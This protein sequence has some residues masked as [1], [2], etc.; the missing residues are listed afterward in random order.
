MTATIERVL[1]YLLVE[2]NDDHADLVERCF[3]YGNVPGQIRRAHCGVDCLAYL[4]AERTS[5]D[6][7]QDTYPD[8]ILMDIRMAG[9][10]DGL[11]TLLAIR[12]DPRHRSL[13]VIMLTSS[14]REKDAHRAYELGADGYIVK[15]FE[16]DEMTE[17]LRQ[18][19]PPFRF[20][21]T[22]LTNSDA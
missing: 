8:V 13:P 17:R 9:T 18:V 10:L 4:D 11:H 20:I 19:R 7:E 3:R 22:I 21:G 6:R 14:D 16:T 15:C 1:T 12:A 5:S 2:D